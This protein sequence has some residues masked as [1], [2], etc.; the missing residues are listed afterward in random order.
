MGLDNGVTLT[1]KANEKNIDAITNLLEI[2]NLEDFWDSNKYEESLQYFDNYIGNDKKEEIDI[3]IDIA[4]WR[5]YWS[6]RNEVVSTLPHFNE[7]DYMF[8]LGSP[9]L[10]QDFIDIMSYFERQGPNCDISSIWTMPEAISHFLQQKS[11]MYK[12]M[13]LMEQLDKHYI[14]YECYFY[15]S[16]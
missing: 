6:F 3:V 9:D 15:D 11:N 2:Y 13:W 5:K 10:V 16:Y 7:D 12:L 8:D 1:I 14:A 4:Y